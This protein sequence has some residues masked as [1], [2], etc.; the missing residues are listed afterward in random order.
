MNNNQ[1][2]VPTLSTHYKKSGEKIVET[3][4]IKK[5]AKVDST[6]HTHCPHCNHA[7]IVN[8]DVVK[9]AR[10]QRINGIIKAVK[11]ANQAGDYNPAKPSVDD[12]DSTR[13]ESNERTIYNVK[14]EYRLTWYKGRAWV[15]V[16]G[17]SWQW[18]VEFPK[19]EKYS[20][21]PQ[22]DLTPISKGAFDKLVNDKLSYKELE[23]TYKLHTPQR[24]DFNFND[25]AGYNQYKEMNMLT[26]EL[27]ETNV[28]KIS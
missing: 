9:Q 18:I 27:L 24:I 14:G 8:R 17:C 21:E 22:K 6:G 1:K 16:A 10:D 12:K 23:R 28:I 13:T 4:T 7:M 20:T 26:P 19:H 11:S 25:R 2:T 15:S 3:T 5:V